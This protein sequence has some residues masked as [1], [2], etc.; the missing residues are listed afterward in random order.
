ML[1]LAC[2]LNDHANCG[3]QTW[4]ECECDPVRVEEKRETD[5]HLGGVEKA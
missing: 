5:A 4:C 1:C 3:L 2:S